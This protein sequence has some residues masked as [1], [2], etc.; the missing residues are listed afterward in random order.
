MESFTHVTPL[1][2]KRLGLRFAIDMS[3]LWGSRGYKHNVSID[4][5]VCLSYMLF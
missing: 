2:F 4:E 1:E 5:S 3:P